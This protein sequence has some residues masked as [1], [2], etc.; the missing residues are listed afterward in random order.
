MWI[1]INTIRHRTFITAAGV[2][3]ALGASPSIASGGPTTGQDIN[4]AGQL[5][6][7]D[8]TAENLGRRLLEGKDAND[9]SDPMNRILD[10]MNRTADRMHQRFDAGPETQVMQQRII[11][12]LD[13][14][15]KLALQNRSKMSAA[16]STGSDRRTMPDANRAKAR[17]DTAK[18]GRQSDS[19][20]RPGAVSDGMKDRARG[21]A[22]RESR[23]RWGRLP[24]RD[25]EQIMQG[26]DDSFVE[27]YR[28]LIEAYYESLA[29]P[30]P[31][32]MDNNRE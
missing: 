22:F 16:S 24:Q 4:S 30:N 17:S 8:S 32:A 21:G 13:D 12:Q 3:A 28:D 31:R 23:R 25:R 20:T 7:D 29:D 11:K 1:Q 27:P 2:F 6:A 14:A 10:L 26:L 19:P 18:T 5:L 9:E 15:I